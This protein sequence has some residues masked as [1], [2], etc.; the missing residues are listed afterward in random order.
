MKL[1][2]EI[3]QDKRQIE[4]DTKQCYNK[5]RKILYWDDYDYITENIY[6]TIIKIKKLKG[7]KNKVVGTKIKWDLQSL[8]LKLD[9]AD[10]VQVDLKGEDL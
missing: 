5:K 1:L 8:F 4:Y 2:D 6:A 10:K 7:V 3:K 9:A